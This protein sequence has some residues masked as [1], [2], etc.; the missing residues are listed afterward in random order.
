MFLTKT[1]GYQKKKKCDKNTNVISERDYKGG[2]LLWSCHDEF[3]Q[4]FEKRF[5]KKTWTNVF[6]HE[7]FSTIDIYFL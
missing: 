4:F 2:L 3:S 7:K 1:D 6:V 5:E